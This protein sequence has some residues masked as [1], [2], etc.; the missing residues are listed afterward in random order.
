[1]ITRDFFSELRFSKVIFGNITKC[2]NLSFLNFVLG[3]VGSGKLCTFLH[4]FYAITAAYIFKKATF[5]KLNNDE[6]YLFV[7]S[8]LTCGTDQTM[9]II[10]AAGEIIICLIPAIKDCRKQRE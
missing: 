8:F 3:K 7:I 1:M 6:Y 9:A 2:N 4:F 5:E 10:H